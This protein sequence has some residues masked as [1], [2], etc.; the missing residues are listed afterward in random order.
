MD[1]LYTSSNGQRQ[2]A[3][4]GSKVT[5]F[6]TLQAASYTNSMVMMGDN[7][8]GRLNSQQ[9]SSVRTRLCFPWGSD[10][11]ELQLF[12]FLF[13]GVFFF[14]FAIQGSYK[15]PAILTCTLCI[16]DLPSRTRSGDAEIR[17]PTA[18]N[19]QPAQCTLVPVSVLLG[20][21]H[22]A[23]G[24]VSARRFATWRVSHPYLAKRVRIALA[25]CRFQYSSFVLYGSFTCIITKST[26]PSTGLRL[27]LLQ[28]IAWQACRKTGSSLKKQSGAP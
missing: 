25:A 28:Y 24:R 6:S 12:L 13:W 17:A 19:A 23:I 4:D 20:R 7:L 22:H 5:C 15:L 3:P 14:F 21:E 8:W 2:T 16:R 27:R 18:A 9:K 10:A 11:A 26:M 1:G